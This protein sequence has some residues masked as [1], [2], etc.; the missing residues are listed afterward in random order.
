MSKIHPV[1]AAG[2]GSRAEMYETAR[3]GYPPEAVAWLVEKS[4]IGPHSEVIDVGAGTGKLTRL[5]S[6]TGAHL[7]AIDPL[8]EMLAVLSRAVPGTPI[9]QAAAED[10][11]LA[12]GSVDA[13]T[14]AQAFH[15]FDAE[16]A[17]T[18]FH[19]VLRPGGAVGLIWNARQR[20]E[21]EWLTRVWEVIDGTE[22][23]APWSIHTDGSFVT[24][25][26]FGPFETATF[27]HRVETTRQ[28]MIDRVATVAHVAAL[29]EDRRA[30]VLDQV[31]EL[32]P[33]TGPLS[34]PYRVD[35][36]VT[37]PV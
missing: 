8:A 10:L 23:S 26:L 27:H 4:G 22:T 24:S 9:V 34:V 7:T 12:D 29:P 37:R 17:W 11:P 21:E 25:E 14:C 20:S 16:R 1:A 15:W 33:R 13:I 30:R 28:S 31:A 36:Y 3:P 32:I 2:F 18:E 5:L 6:A 19:R 35:C